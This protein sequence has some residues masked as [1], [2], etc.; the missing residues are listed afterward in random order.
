MALDT[1]SDTFSAGD[2][3]DPAITAVATDCSEGI[4]AV[5]ITDFKS[6]LNQYRDDTKGKTSEEGV[7]FFL[8]TNFAY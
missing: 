3:T 6:R 4:T 8:D 7:P 2:T 5:D 1:P